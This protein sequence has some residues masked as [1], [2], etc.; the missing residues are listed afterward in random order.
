[1]DGL[2]I[3]NTL[4]RDVEAF[5]PLRDNRV[6]MF[7]C[8]PTVYDY[9]HLGHA[10]TYVFYDVVARYLRYRGYSVFFLMNITDVDDKIINRAKEREILV[11]LNG[12]PL[13][14]SQL[15][16]KVGPS[17]EYVR[18]RLEEMVR[19]GLVEIED[20]PGLRDELLKLDDELRRAETYDERVK[21][22]NRI[23]D[24][25]DRIGLDS[26][27]KLTQLGEKALA[28]LKDRASV[29]DPIKLA[30]EFEEYFKEDMLK[31]GIDSINLYA[32]ASEF[33]S[34]IISMAKT[35]QE[36]GYAY[37][38]PTALYFDSTKFEDYGKLSGVDPR[39]EYRRH[40]IE[41]DPTKRS[42]ADWALWRKI[43]A[44]QPDKPAWESPW[45][46]GRPGWHIEDTAITTTLFGPSYDIHGGAKELIFPHHEA[47]IAQAEAATGVKPFVRYWIHTDVLT[48]NG[49][50]MSKSLGNYITVRDALKVFSPEVLRYW[51]L[52]TRYRHRIDLR[53]PFE[54]SL[55]NPMKPED[56][57][58]T[59]IKQAEK[60][61]N[62][63]YNVL[64]RIETMEKAEKM[65]VEAEKLAEKLRWMREEFLKAMDDDFDTPKA[66]AILHEFATEFFKYCQKNSAINKR[67]AYEISSTF[68]E[69]GSILGILQGKPVAAADI[70]FRDLIELIV[71]VRDELRKSRDY[72]KADKI[73]ERLRALGIVLEDTPKGTIWRLARPRQGA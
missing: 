43:K 4:K 42:D 67:L 66:I 61:L 70:L 14:L 37:E 73:R 40:R 68:R 50:K 18:R 11:A 58:E 32:R 53:L 5:K 69:L 45:G 16:S 33:I 30:R 19:F 13:T 49:R 6:N 52:L 72:E 12:G 27:V 22:E 56:L 57:Q 24:T 55:V 38:T 60:G 10:K 21:L 51:I 59:A 44:G 26:R 71:E 28:S 46:L 25:L 35:L 8:G 29:Q 41:P 62:R 9:M 54:P 39:A 63:L 65:N 23:R 15:V 36:K 48:V 2:R 3:Y 34:E 64:Q 17:E 31:L 47:E 7:V 20:L 1:M